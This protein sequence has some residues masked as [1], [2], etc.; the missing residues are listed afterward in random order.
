MSRGRVKMEEENVSGG[1][2]RGGEWGEGLPS[3]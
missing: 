3:G 1:G 2:N